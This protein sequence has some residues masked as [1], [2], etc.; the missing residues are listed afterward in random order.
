MTLITDASAVAAWLMPDEAGYDL[1]ELARQHDDFIAPMLLWIEL[2]NILLV[3]ERRKRLKAGEAENA[4][5]ALA[6]LG[7]ALD[8]DPSSAD[9]LR[10]AR[11]HSLSGHDA[12]YLE[13]AVRRSGAL[14]TGDAALVRAA[15]AEGV[16]VV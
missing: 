13:L 4:L 15:Q 10:L 11:S 16:T 8:A 3:A 1:V 12:L 14:A 2:R 7:I 5:A 6:Q 9:V